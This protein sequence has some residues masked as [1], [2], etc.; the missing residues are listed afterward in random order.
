[1]KIALGSALM[2][3]KIGKQRKVGD[4]IIFK[5]RQEYLDK[6]SFD[7]RERRENL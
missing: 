7:H 4:G 1:M 3:A 5:I 6:I 2:R